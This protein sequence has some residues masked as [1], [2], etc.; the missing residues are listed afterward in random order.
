[1]NKVLLACAFLAI[2]ATTTHAQHGHHGG[3]SHKA[4]ASRSQHEVHVR[5]T[6]RKDGTFVPAHERT[7]PNSTN[8]DNWSTKGN[9][10]PYTGKPGTVE[11]DKKPR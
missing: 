7:S 3:G 11:P 1:M 10:N 8:R 6:T 5:A 9:V 4:S 2:G